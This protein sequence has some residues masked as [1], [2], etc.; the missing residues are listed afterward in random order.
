[1]IEPRTYPDE[2]KANKE[3]SLVFWFYTSF[4]GKKP[5]ATHYSSGTKILS[6]ILRESK[7]FPGAR[8]YTLKEVADT[9]YYL[10]DSGVTRIELTILKF[11]NLL[12][13]F[14]EKETGKL[15]DIVAYLSRGKA[16]A[17]EW[18]PPAGW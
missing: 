5:D 11:P 17:N 6:G 3:S 9:L 4:L 12:S 15:S 13:A 16:S 8:V 14:A 7:K 10:R 1:M 18:S 2:T